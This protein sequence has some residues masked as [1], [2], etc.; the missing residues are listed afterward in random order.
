[1]CPLARSL[2]AC[3]FVVA[4]PAA[5]CDTALMLA[6]DVSQSV[7][8][9]EYRL[10]VDGMADAL[11]A[12]EI[13]DAMVEGQVAIAVMQ[14]SGS[15]RQELSIPWTRIAGPADAAALSERARG[16]E[17]A[18]VMSDTAP[19]D[20]IAFALTAFP[21][22]ADCR[23][24]VLDISGDGTPNAGAD[25]GAARRAAER[26]GVTINA[27]AIEGMGLA[28]TNFYDR[29]VISTDG[30]V[31]TARGHRDYPGAIRRKILRELSVIF[32]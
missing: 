25:V 20:A 22:V 31:V 2:A 12:P 5:A 23:R 15:E 16:L 28:I 21:Q 3:L 6:I 10:Q 17:R 9:A 8:V 24:R 29:S 19:G 32:G 4:P 14:W 7:D 26:A 27:I 30:F 1:M 11:G 13:V 18:F